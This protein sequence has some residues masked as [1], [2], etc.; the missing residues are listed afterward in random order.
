M[1]NNECCKK[2][3]HKDKDFNV[4]EIFCPKNLEGN[5]ISNFALETKNLEGNKISTF[6]LEIRN[7]NFLSKN[8]IIN[9]IIINYDISANLNQK[10]DEEKD[11]NENYKNEKG[12]LN[13]MKLIKHPSFGN[14][15]FIEVFIQNINLVRSDLLGF[16]R[17]LLEYIDKFDSIQKKIDEIKD[18]EERSA[19][20]IN[21]EDIKNASDILLK[22]HELNIKGINNK[23]NNFIQIDDFK[24]PIP[25]NYEDIYKRNYYDKFK[26]RFKFKFGKNFKL[27][28]S[29]IGTVHHDKEISFLLFIV[30]IILNKNKFLFETN[31]KYI[32]IDYEDNIDRT[33]L[34]TLVLVNEK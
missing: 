8:D 14:M 17:K 28:D 30:R 4:E 32:A 20:S 15:D 10:R 34:L 29:I 26:K 5:K 3:I 16:S 22:F 7:S 9:Q 21:K 23:L 1:G 27:I 33:N 31:A 24:Y 13:W 11:S 6:A 2:F 25:L 12:L 18:D 19:I